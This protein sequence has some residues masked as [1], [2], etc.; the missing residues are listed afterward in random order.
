MARREPWKSTRLAIWI[1]QRRANQRAIWLDEHGAFAPLYVPALILP[2]SSTVSLCHPLSINVP[3]LW[4]MA[5][6]MSGSLA[7][8]DVDQ[9]KHRFPLYLSL[10]TIG[11]VF[12]LLLHLTKD[13]AYIAITPLVMLY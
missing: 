1:K 2:S 6:F 10:T 13:S 3:V 12:G 5:M 9:A 11:L 8:L 7:S 4:L